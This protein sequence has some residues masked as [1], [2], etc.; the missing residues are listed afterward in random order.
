MNYAL[1]LRLAIYGS[2]MGVGSYITVYLFFFILP[3]YSTLLKLYSKAAIRD[4]CWTRGYVVVWI[5]VY[6]FVGKLVNG[7]ICGTEVV[8]P[9]GALHN[10]ILNLVL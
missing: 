6:S 3:Y 1:T 10:L 8:G 9:Y 5:L 4:P 7:I 2:C